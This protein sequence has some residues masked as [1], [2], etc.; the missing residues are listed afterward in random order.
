VLE[1]NLDDFTLPDILRL[2]AFTSKTGR[3]AIQRD[4]VAGRI[5]LFDGR[6]REA[7]ADADR[8]V[9]A[10]RLLG[11]G[12]VSADDLAGV[13]SDRGTLPS[14]LELARA[15]AEAGAAGSGTLA[16][17]L[18]EQT[19]DA[20]FDLLRWTEGS[21]RFEGGQADPRGEE[22]LDLAVPVD[23]VLTEATSRLEA[24]PTVA[25]RTGAPDAIVTIARPSGDRRE[26]SLPPDGWSL[27][28]LVDGRRTVAE[29][30]H[31]SG[32]GEFRTRRTL[33]ALLDEEVVTVG[34]TGRTGHIERLLADHDR[35]AT[36]ERDL[37]AAA[38]PRPAGR[39]APEPTPASP[40]AATNPT[41][42]PTPSREWSAPERP[43]VSA[44]GG[45]DGR[46]VAAPSARPGPVTVRSEEVA[47]VAGDDDAVDAA[48][49]AKARGGRLRTDPS[50]DAD[51]V[52]R[53]I[54]GVES[55]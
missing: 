33:V 24:W 53:L 29:L 3:L 37:G 32:Q 39:A 51:L 7:S 25:E 40:P 44:G 13:L 17:V 23:E 45:V 27:L 4:G 22:V 15:L 34:E 12:L 54:D 21:F 48:A 1:G 9:I 5:D 8:L 11:A 47:T 26:V 43:N 10:R 30:A 6:V 50:V 55:L 31:L 2:L 28:S 36:L 20:V 42:E 35:L 16:E 52:R 49:R 19:V 14:D 38:R 46:R 18:R 41:A